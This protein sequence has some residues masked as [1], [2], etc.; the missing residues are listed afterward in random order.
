MT[1]LARLNNAFPRPAL[2][3]ALCLFLAFCV[4]AQA[5]AIISKPQAEGVV[6]VVD[7]KENKLHLA[8]NK[9]SGLEVFQSYDATLGQ[10]LGDKNVE[11]DRKTPE[12]IY[13]FE[14]R[15]LPSTG[16]KPKFGSMALYV[17]Y[18]NVVDRRGKK[19]GF[20]ILI[21]GTND[22]D[23]L[24]KKY[25]SLGCIVVANEQIDAIWPY[26]RLKDT[27]LIVTRDFS[28]LQSPTRKGKAKAF[29]D[30]WITAW[31]SKDIDTYIDSYAYEFTYDKMDRLT[32]GKYKDRLNKIYESI[33]VKADNVQYFFHEKYDVIRFD[34]TYESTLPGGKKGYFLEATKELYIQERNGQ[35][36]I[37]A[38]VTVKR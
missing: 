2:T 22:P 35:Y 29:L 9:P 13:Q 14:F 33:N 30:Q 21:H 16:L 25:D 34:Q 1:K 27:K 15:S 28:A 23:R 38:E 7:K 11:G 6:I 3:F 26:V 19:T 8:K 31:S 18:P 10:V 36:K 12:G 17:N 5:D 37:L 24:K 32:Y 20:D 4:C